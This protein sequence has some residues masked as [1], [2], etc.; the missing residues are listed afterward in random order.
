MNF[1]I[2]E[3]QQ[4]YD[5]GARS[6]NFTEVVPEWLGLGRVR[7]RLFSRATGRVLETGVGTGFSLKYYPEGIDLTAVDMS[8]GM[9]KIARNRA[10]SLSFSTTFQQ[11]NVQEL[12]FDDHSFDTV[13]D[14]LCLCTYPDPVKALQEMMRVCKPGG[15][16]LLLEHGLS[17]RNWM[18]RYQYWR[19]EAQ[20]KP[21]GCCWTREP[22]E[23][24]KQAGINILSA[25]RHFLGMFHE[26]I[27]EPKVGET[28]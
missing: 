19:A 4:K 1:S 23:L 13:C 2:T 14:S 28:Q 5:A 22:Q 18:K 6:Y 16:L 7:R 25:R 15:R 10:V 26:V 17:D 9:L 24:M 8:E 12:E 11:M 20:A 27:A 3:I 21:L